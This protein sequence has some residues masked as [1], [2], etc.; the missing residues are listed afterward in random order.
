MTYNF[1][2]NTILI[3]VITQVKEVLNVSE[4]I[5]SVPM[6]TGTNIGSIYKQHIST[7]LTTV[8]S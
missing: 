3:H 5:Q 2:K 7:T 8:S 4:F 1:D 6:T